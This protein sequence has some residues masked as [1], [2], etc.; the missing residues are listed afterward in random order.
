MSTEHEGLEAK[1]SM[2]YDLITLIDEKPDQKNYSAEEVKLMIRA[3][4]K[5]AEN[6]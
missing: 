2:A 5:A 1:K 3:Y 4:I 6:K